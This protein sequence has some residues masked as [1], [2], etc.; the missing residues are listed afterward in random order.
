MVT[1]KQQ[2][3]QLFDGLDQKGRDSLLDYAQFLTS[4]IPQRDAEREKHI[5][6][7]P[8]HQPRPAEESVL[9]AI[10]RLR[11]SYYMIDTDNMINDTSSLM[12]QFMLHGRPAEEVIDDLE[13]LF[14]DNYQKYLES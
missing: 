10:K 9:S 1:K 7:E 13:T 4:K 2:L 6:H 3:A 12:T 14:N 8:R 11:A 5:K